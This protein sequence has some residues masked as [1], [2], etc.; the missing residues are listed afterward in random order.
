[1]F[2]DMMFANQKIFLTGGA[3]FIGSHIA[4]SLL[5]GGAQLTIYDNFSSG[6]MENLHKIEGR[7]QIIRGDICDYPALEA[8]MRGHN[9]VSH[10]AAQL[11]ILKCV[12]DPI[13]DLQVNT[14]GT[15]NVLRAAKN[16]G[17]RKVV[18]ASSA[19]VYGQTDVEQQSED[20]ATQPNWAYGVSKLAGEHYARIY[21]TD[22][23][24]P[25]V[26]L[27][28]GII[29]G[30]REWYGRVFTIFLKRLFE[31][32]PLVVFGDGQQ[33]RDFTY[34]GDVVRMH[35]LCLAS[36]RANG[37]TY[38]VATGIGTTVNTLAA[39]VAEAGGGLEVLHENV[40]EG[41]YSKIMPE[42]VRLPA[43]LKVMTLSPAKALA[44]LGW[45]P[46]V[47]LKDGLQHQIAWLKDHLH[48][49]HT[50]HI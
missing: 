37:Q 29:Y 22:Y 1:M 50:V 6:S 34:V 23:G 28:Y 31:R 36:D 20:H 7:V 18:L 27:R 24:L 30:P 33:R 2:R 35:N 38:N 8:A 32:K 5:A 19:C 48:R 17:V 13:W 9:L 14:G 47:A 39:L 21:M 45:K 15:I 46:E 49:W 44:E 41:E 11:E 16:L 43:E 26:N 42:R 3:G 10:Q 25:V 40:K 4:E 12:D